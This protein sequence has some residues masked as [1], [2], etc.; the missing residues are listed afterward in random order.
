M[1][2]EYPEPQS[3]E[4]PFIVYASTTAAATA[5]T[6]VISR[7]DYP[8]CTVEYV[9]EGGGF[10]EINDFSARIGKDSIYFLT[11]GSHHSYWP[12]RES[13]WNKLFFVV[14]GSLAFSLLKAYKM[15]HC[16]LIENAVSL[17]K[18]FE[19]MT[20]ASSDPSG[21]LPSLVFHRFLQ[22]CTALQQGISP[23]T[24]EPPPLPVLTL[25]QV[26]D[27][28][29]EGI[30][31]LEEFSAEQGMSQAHLIRLFK[32][33]FQLTPYEYLMKRKMERACSLLQ[34]SSLSIKEIAA[35]LNFSDQYYFSNYFRRRCGVSP[36]E[37]RKNA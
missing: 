20:R 37:Y 13:P 10:L 36:R 19:E 28:A 32:S 30:F 33:H 9:L 27:D 11:P 21:A 24:S 26:L 7:R 5:R 16:Y 6:A 8:V 2:Q 3:H 23:V 17:K 12:D 22:A 31:R 14:G 18:Y 4:F 29:V 25:K 34:Y 15:E 35:R 1:T